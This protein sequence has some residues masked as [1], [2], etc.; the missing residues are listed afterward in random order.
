MLGYPYF[1]GPKAGR[2]TLDTDF[3]SGQI[4]GILSQEQDGQEVVIAYGSKKLTKSQR[5][6]PSTKGELYAGMAWMIKYRYY[7]QYGKPFKWRTDNNALKAIRTMDCP[8]GI[9]ERWLNTLADFNFDVEHRA[10]TK[11]TNADGL[12]RSNVPNS[13][14]N[15]E[16]HDLE[17]PDDSHRSSSRTISLLDT[18]AF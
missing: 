10:G 13:Y 15:H 18:T 7:L 16:L 6:W 14:D 17:E 1:S 5:N 3:S 12:S 11:H 9:V 4:A 8:S 2:F